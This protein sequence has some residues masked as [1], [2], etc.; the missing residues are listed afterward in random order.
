M[1]NDL[2]PPLCYAVTQIHLAIELLYNYFKNLQIK[3]F[4]FRGN[5]QG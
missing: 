4:I 5:S 3:L 2:K 1:M